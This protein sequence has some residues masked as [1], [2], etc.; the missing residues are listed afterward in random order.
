MEQSVERLSTALVVVRSCVRVPR[1]YSLSLS[2]PILLSL[3]AIVIIII[4]RIVIYTCIFIRQM[5][6]AIGII[7][8]H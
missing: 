1:L 5:T 4:V 8:Q 7:I 2:L 3:S 6:I